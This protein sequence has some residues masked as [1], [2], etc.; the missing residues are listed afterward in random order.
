[1]TIIL[2]ILA[3]AGIVS[4]VA[5]KI[6]GW[7]NEKNRKAK[8]G[9]QLN[10]HPDALAVRLN[11]FAENLTK[12]AEEAQKMAAEALKKAQYQEGDKQ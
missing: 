10:A 2:T 5:W 3:T 6:H 9:A 8:E 4:Y 11:R 7:H 1:M 12:Q